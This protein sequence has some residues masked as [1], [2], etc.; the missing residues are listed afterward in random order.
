MCHRIENQENAADRHPEDAGQ[1]AGDF[2]QP[3]GKGHHAETGKPLVP[4]EWLHP[5][6]TGALRQLVA[7]V[8]VP[9]DRDPAC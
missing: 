5:A 2:A 8:Q 7:L 3:V 9:K 4:Q 6:R 1:L